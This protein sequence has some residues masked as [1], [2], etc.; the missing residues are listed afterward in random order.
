MDELIRYNA[1]VLESK[2]MVLCMRELKNRYRCNSCDRAFKSVR[3]IY[4]RV[5]DGRRVNTYYNFCCKTCASKGSFAMDLLI[6]LNMNSL[7][8]FK[9]MFYSILNMYTFQNGMVDIIVL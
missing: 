2:K 1:C 3:K 5:V 9:S 8:N 7:E 6:T 4:I